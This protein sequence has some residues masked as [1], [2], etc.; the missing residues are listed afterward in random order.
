M[1]NNRDIET[2]QERH[3]K[4]L[5]KKREQMREHGKSLGKIYRDAVEK[6]MKKTEK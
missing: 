5:K 3:E 4:K 2:R 6:R 1:S